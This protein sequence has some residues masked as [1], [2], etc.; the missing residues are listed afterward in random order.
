MRNVSIFYFSGTGNTWWTS[1]QFCRILEAKGFSAAA[2]SI[3]SGRNIIKERLDSA[4][5]VFLLYPIY[6]SDRP[7]IVKNFISSLPAVQNKSFGII[8]TQLMFSGNGAWM[9]HEL[10]ESK[11]YKIK[12]AVHLKMPNNVS[13]PGFPFSFTNDKSKLEPTLKKAE[14]R[15]IKIAESVS[16]DRPLLQGTSLFSNLFGNMQ[17]KPYR[18][19]FHSFQNAVSIDPERCTRCGKCIRLCP[20][21][22]IRFAEEDAGGFPEFQGSC[23]LC[24]RCYNFCPEQAVMYQGRKFISRGG[25]K[26]RPYQGPVEDF[27]P[28]LLK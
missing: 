1:V 27:K 11:G 19:M 25:G 10:I 13:I 17:R 7:E 2:V 18:R 26:T 6:G 23:N 21:E 20:V 5:I 16:S 28:E 12:W 15:L 8:C 22:N 24:L 14:E 9:E 3:E 4:E